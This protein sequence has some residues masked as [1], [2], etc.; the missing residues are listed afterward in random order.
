MIELKRIV[1]QIFG[2]AV[3]SN[4]GAV[5]PNDRV[6]AS[7]GIVIVLTAFLVTHGSFAHANA[8]ARMFGSGSVGTSVDAVLLS[9]LSDHA[10]EI[11]V[12]RV[13]RCNVAFVFL[14]A[15]LLSLSW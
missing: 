9:E 10:N 1:I 6:Q 4:L 13:A 5:D 2:N 3:H 8:N 11:N 7:N 12:T 15:T 14:R